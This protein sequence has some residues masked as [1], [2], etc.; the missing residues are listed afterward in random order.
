MRTLIL[1]TK[2]QSHYGPLG[3][4]IWTLEII[5]ISM[6]DLTHDFEYKEYSTHTH[7]PFIGDWGLYYGREILWEGHVLPKERKIMF[8]TI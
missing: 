3:R 1:G 7:T 5:T 4:L 8:E 6:S 2:F